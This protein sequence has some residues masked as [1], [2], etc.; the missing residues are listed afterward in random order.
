[1]KKIVFLLMIIGLVSCDAATLQKLMDSAGQ[2]S[3]SDL[4]IS[5]GLKEALN[6]GVTSGVNY[7]SAKNGF[8][9]SPYKILLPTDAQKVADKLKVIPGFDK[10]ESEVTT[11]LNRA[12]EDA[13]ATAKP[14]FIDAIK[15]MTFSDVRN[16]LFGDDNAATQY[17]QKATSSKLYDEFHPI[18]VNSLNKYNALTYWSDAVNTYNKIPF[19]NK[20][21]PELDDY[22]TQKAMDGLFS[23][24]AVKELDIRTNLAS[25]TSDLLKKVFGLQDSK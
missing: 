6:N 13:V 5:N 14:I 18:I 1:M 11:R 23:L 7:L 2:T 24:V 3:I 21:N 25:R 8:L 9:E 20:M 10:V 16:I 19:V 22:V 15:Q 4:E 12:A 17:L